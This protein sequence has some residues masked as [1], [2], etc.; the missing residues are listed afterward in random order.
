MVVNECSMVNILKRWEIWPDCSVFILVSDNCHSHMYLHLYL[1]TFLK[2]CELTGYFVIKNWNYL[3]ANLTLN[4]LF[5]S[6]ASLIKGYFKVAK[7]KI[8]CQFSFKMVNHVLAEI[9]NEIFGVD[10]GFIKVLNFQI[11]LCQHF[12]IIWQISK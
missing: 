1:D 8:I 5:Q 6:R 2:R 3:K 10:F 12:F 11:F 7:W 4:V 9:G